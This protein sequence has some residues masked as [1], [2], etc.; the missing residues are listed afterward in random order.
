MPKRARATAPISAVH[1]CYWNNQNFMKWKIAHPIC[2]YLNYCKIKNLCVNRCNN[3]LYHL[4]MYIF[5]IV[6]Q[7][8]LYVF[9]IS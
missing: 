1:S 4:T 6:L 2:Y 3:I 8:I 9:Y 5:R 7:C